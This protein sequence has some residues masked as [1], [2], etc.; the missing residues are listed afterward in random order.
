MKASNKRRY[1]NY[2]DMDPFIFFVPYLR[3]SSYHTYTRTFM[4]YYDMWLTFKNHRMVLHSKCENM[5]SFYFHFRLYHIKTDFSKKGEEEAIGFHIQ[6]VVG[7]DAVKWGFSSFWS[8]EMIWDVCCN[9]TTFKSMK[10]PQWL[11]V[12]YKRRGKY[13]CSIAHLFADC[14]HLIYCVSQ[15]SAII[16]RKS[17][18]KWKQEFRSP[19]FI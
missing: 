3:H 18:I 11:Y 16:K 10:Q 7:N 12:R 9:I 8:W 13:E 4:T 19:L 17:K 14:W 2:H 1:N 15:W 5:I 6:F